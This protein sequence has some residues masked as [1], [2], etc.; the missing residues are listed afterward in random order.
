MMSLGRMVCAL[1]LPTMK[2]IKHELL[3]TEQIT[4]KASLHV[5]GG[6]PHS[7]SSG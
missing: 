5:W 3:M 1:Q 6:L 4:A 7:Y 2:S